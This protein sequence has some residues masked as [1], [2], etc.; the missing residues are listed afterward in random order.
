VAAL[1][2]PLTVPWALDKLALAAGGVVLFAAAYLGEAVRAGLQIVARGQMDASLSLGLRPMQAMR[3]VVLPQAFRVVL[4][5]LVAIAVA[6]FQDTSLVVI[7]GLFDLLNTARA[8]AQDPAWLG[9]YDEAYVF[10]GALYFLG[11]LG[12]TRYGLWLERRSRSERTG[13]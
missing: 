8:A 4:P 11:S 6:F 1:V 7:I 3:L 13:A 9:F 2:V 10:V 12:A 5:S